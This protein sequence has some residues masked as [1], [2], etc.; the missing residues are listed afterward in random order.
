MIFKLGLCQGPSAAC[1]EMSKP[2]PRRGFTQ[3]CY[4]TTDPSFMHFAYWTFIFT[5]SSKVKRKKNFVEQA[6]WF[7]ELRHWLPN[8]MTEFNLWNPC[9][10]RENSSKLSSDL[11]TRYGIHMRMYTHTHTHTQTHTK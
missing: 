1:A 5:R 3:F 6:R 4:G 2:L 11:H 8:L 9:G 10:V 7:S